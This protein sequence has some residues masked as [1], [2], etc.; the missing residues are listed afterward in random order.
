MA[1]LRSVSSSA[2]VAPELYNGE[3]ADLS[4]LDAST[5]LISV[6]IKRILIPGELLTTTTENQN[7]PDIRHHVRTAQF[8]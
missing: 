8:A 7:D 5:I 3:E 4:N 1:K 6:Y 2:L